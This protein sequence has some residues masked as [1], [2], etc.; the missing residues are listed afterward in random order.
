[1][2]PVSVLDVI[3]DSLTPVLKSSTPLDNKIKDALKE[4]KPEIALSCDKNEAT[5]DFQFWAGGSQSFFCHL[6]SCNFHEG[7]VSLF[8]FVFAIS[9]FLNCSD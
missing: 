6:N 4:R 2:W 1:M 3:K 7:I 9:N 8:R 5:C